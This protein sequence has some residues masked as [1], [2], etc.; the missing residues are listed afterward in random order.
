MGRRFWV[1][2]ARAFLCAFVPVAGMFIF[3]SWERSA[4]IVLGIAGAAVFAVIATA[5]G[6]AIGA[7][8]CRLHL[9][10]I[11]RTSGW[12]LGAASWAAI[13]GAGTLGAVAGLT[14]AILVC[15]VAPEQF[16]DRSPIGLALGCTI[17]SG[18]TGL[19]FGAGLGQGA[20]L[21]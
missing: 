5:P 18:A 21:T 1:A 8:A 6:I 13:L 2:V 17:A 10:A 7:T 11:H 14:V 3:A 16:P 9:Q 19:L 12:L 20:R 15:W 4:A